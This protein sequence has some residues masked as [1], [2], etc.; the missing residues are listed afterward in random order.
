ML[1]DPPILLCDEPTTGLDSF[2]ASQVVS[3]LRQFA[4]KGKTA[5]RLN[6]SIFVG[7]NA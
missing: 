5:D 1:P 6:S 7:V 2:S 4:A 3:L